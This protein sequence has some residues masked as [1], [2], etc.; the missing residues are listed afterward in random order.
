MMASSKKPGDLGGHYFNIFWKS[1]EANIHL[2]F[3]SQG[4]TCS[5]FISARRVWEVSPPFLGKRA[6]Y[7]SY[8]SDIIYA[9]TIL[10]MNLILKLF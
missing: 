7:Q 9:F 8:W 4:L 1:Y 10:K 6:T 3:H 5:R 2:K